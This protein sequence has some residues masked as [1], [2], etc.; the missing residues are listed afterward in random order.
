MTTGIINGLSVGKR[1]FTEN[2]NKAYEK[3]THL[4]IWPWSDLVSYVKKFIKINEKLKVLEIGCGMGAN[5]PFL[6]SLGV[7]YYGVD[8]SE[9]AIKRLQAKFPTL[10]NRLVVEDFTEKIPFSE[11]FDLIIDRCSL[12]H[13]DTNSISKCIRMIEKRLVDN[14]T[15]MGID[16]WSQKDSAYQQ[17]GEFYDDCSKFNFKSSRF[18][19]IGMVHFSNKKHL[20]DLFTKFNFQILEHKIRS[21]EIPSENQILA[22]YDFVATKK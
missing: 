12:T 14:G 16:W 20:E 10:K 5:I 19:N 2:W 3:N 9:I 22:S 21:K 17:D 8:G 11:S 13:N 6:L 1:D 18:K 15:F 7:Q 4:S